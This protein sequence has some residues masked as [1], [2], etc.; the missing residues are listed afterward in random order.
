MVSRS[1]LI[2]PLFDFLA[3]NLPIKSLEAAYFQRQ[4]KISRALDEQYL[5][6][7]K[8][9]IRRS[10][11]LLL[12]PPKRWRTGG[13][14]SYAEWGH[15]IGIFQTLFMQHMQ[16]V[17]APQI[18]DVGCGTG[19]LGIAAYPLIAGGGTYTGIEVNP[20]QVAFCRQHYPDGYNFTHHEVYNATYATDQPQESKPWDIADASQDLVTALSVWT[21]FSEDDATFYLKE[22]SRVLQPGGKAIITFFYLDEHYQPERQRQQA[23]S[24]TYHITP[25]QP[26]VFDVAASESGDWLHPAWVSVPEDAIGITPKGMDRMLANTDLQ[27]IGYHPG[28]WK[29]RPGV[30]FQDVLIFQKTFDN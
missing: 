18:L 17:Q 8:Q 25:R 14:T 9:Q 26:W 4:Q 12:L 3:Q 15:V 20:E 6:F 1:D 24:E 22:V 13:K 29:N 23:T 27:R 16:G 21:H 19:L 5:S 10:S 30:Y 7:D 2:R 11:S 28:N